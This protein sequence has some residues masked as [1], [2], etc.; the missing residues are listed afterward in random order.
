MD[1][2]FMQESCDSS[3]STERKMT[4]S[5]TPEDLI[6]YG[7]PTHDIAGSIQSHSPYYAATSP[8][9]RRRTIAN[10][11]PLA[12]SSILR[13]FTPQRAKNVSAVSNDGV[14]QAG[15][16]RLLLLLFHLAN[17]IIKTMVRV[18]S[19][20]FL[21]DDVQDVKCSLSPLHEVV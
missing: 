7:P 5:W 9:E 8:V 15:A 16:S 14:M 1:S 18:A 17:D 20:Q 11:F 10:G 19:F 13:F 21:I 12:S 4:S 6:S 2:D 3:Q